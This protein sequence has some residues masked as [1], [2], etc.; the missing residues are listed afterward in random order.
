M[1]EHTEAGRA[2]VVLW[3]QTSSGLAANI[4]FTSAT[5][6]VVVNLSGENYMVL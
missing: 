3:R 6:L 1:N 2:R 5:C 4:G